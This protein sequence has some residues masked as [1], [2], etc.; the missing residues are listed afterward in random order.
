MSANPDL[1]AYL[2]KHWKHGPES[3]RAKLIDDGVDEGEIEAAILEAAPKP[4]PSQKPARMPLSILSGVITAAFVFWAF[5]NKGEQTARSPGPKQVLVQENPNDPHQAY[6]G[7]YGYMMR[8]PLGYNASSDFLDPENTI[9]V[10]YLYPKGTDL[11]N[12]RDEGIYKPLGI[13]RLEVQPRPRA[14]PEGRM[15]IAVLQRQVQV[16][17]QSRKIGFTIHE[18][19]VGGLPA[20]VVESKEP[21]AKAEAFIVGSKV[22]YKLVGGAE[23]QLFTDTLQSIHEVGEKQE[24]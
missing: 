24:Q 19:F 7:H 22:I 17:L 14:I 5:R 23:D 6:I 9:E 18:I 4:K 10:V 1:V 16:A 3:L 20:I 8:L 15:G 12:L 11:T 2:R 21:A 13:L